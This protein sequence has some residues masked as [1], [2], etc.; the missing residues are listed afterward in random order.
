[1]SKNTLLN[2]FTRSP[3]ISKKE[4][5]DSSLNKENDG[6]GLSK[7]PKRKKSE[8]SP[9]QNRSECGPPSAAV[10]TDRKD[11]SKVHNSSNK[12]PSSSKKRAKKVSLEN[13]NSPSTRK[14]PVEGE[15]SLLYLLLN[16][17]IFFYM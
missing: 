9:L 14:S 12:T 13:F 6:D 10:T 5:G 17:T 4:N 8:S 15:C 7:T 1:M 2:Y 11:S 3:V 16:N